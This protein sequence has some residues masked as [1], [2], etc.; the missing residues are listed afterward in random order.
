M[1]TG[2]KTGART[3]AVSS[4]ARNF[5]AMPGKEGGSRAKYFMGNN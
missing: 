4:P 1:N 5:N 2:G 3:Q